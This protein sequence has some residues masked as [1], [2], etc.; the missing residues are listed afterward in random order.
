MHTVPA[1]KILNIRLPVCNCKPKWKNIANHNHDHNLNANRVP[2]QK[3][4]YLLQSRSYHWSVET[5][6]WPHQR[7]QPTVW[8]FIQDRY[9]LILILS[10]STS[11]ISERGIVCQEVQHCFRVRGLH[12]WWTKHT[13]WPNCI[14]SISHARSQIMHRVLIICALNSIQFIW[15]LSK[16]Q[17]ILCIIGIVFGNIP[18]CK[19]FS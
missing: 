15:R 10:T 13:H 3:T 18:F 5:S 1:A 12:W 11:A 17:F 19:L 9:W 7:H 14:V 6:H 8:S 16:L 2:N 4:Y